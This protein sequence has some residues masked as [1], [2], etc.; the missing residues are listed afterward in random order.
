VRVKD[1]KIKSKKIFEIIT[2][3]CKF[4]GSEGNEVMVG[5]NNLFKYKIK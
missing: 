3:F 4:I 1:G 2:F 5:V